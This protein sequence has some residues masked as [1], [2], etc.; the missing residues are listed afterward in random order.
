MRCL[1]CRIPALRRLR[2]ELARIFALTLVVV[3]AGCD[4]ATAPADPAP[5]ADRAP[6]ADPAPVGLATVGTSRI[7]FMSYTNEES[8][9]YT[10]GQGGGGL[11]RLTSWAG[12]EWD[13][14]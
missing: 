1:L 13:P 9:L 12:S 8:D 3:L 6:V 4:D 11:T 14:T 5:V 2:R 10:I 7:A